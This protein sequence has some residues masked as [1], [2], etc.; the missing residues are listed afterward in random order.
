VI[1]KKNLDFTNCT[2]CEQRILK[3]YQKGSKIYDNEKDWGEKFLII[4]DKHSVHQVAEEK[5]KI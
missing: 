3:Y 1:I 4:K 2:L 5:L